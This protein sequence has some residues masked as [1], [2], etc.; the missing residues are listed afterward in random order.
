ME[1]SCFCGSGAAWSSP[2]HALT[3]SWEFE[4][5]SIYTIN[6]EASFLKTFLTQFGPGLPLTRGPTRQVI[7]RVDRVED[8]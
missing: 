6:S 8:P 7:G 5:V 2:K 1:R 3:A 4:F